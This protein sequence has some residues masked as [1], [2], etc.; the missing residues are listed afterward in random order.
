[1]E[2]FTVGMGQMRVEGADLD[3]NLRRAREMIRRAAEAGCRLV[4]LPEC[5]D[6]GWAHPAARELAQ[7]IPGATSDFL[8]TAAQETGLYV[9]AGLTERAGKRLYNAAVLLSPAGEILLKHRKINLL[10][11]VEGSYT[12][13]DSLSVAR[14]PLG[15]LGVNICAD[16]FPNSLAL[17]HTQARMGAQV[18][19]SPSAWAVDA[20]H[21][22]E[23]EPYGALWKGAYATLAGLYDL[24]VIGVSSVGPVRG[25]VWEGRKCIGCSLAVGPGG[26]LLAE[27]P[28]GADAE[29][30]VTVEVALVSP[31]VTGT[32]FAGML[33]SRGY[34]GP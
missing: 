17:A 30:L 12:V 19:L 5:L 24:T 25:G 4:V 9:V 3:G 15:V 6:V 29:A 28:Y 16:N 26:R 22:P 13:G 11:D 10:H 8:A 1:M 23:T 32:G 14:T 34:T 2:R 7:S 18:L 27:A 31:R 20:D 33:Q 21:D